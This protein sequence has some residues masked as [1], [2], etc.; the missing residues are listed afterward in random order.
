MCIHELLHARPERRVQ[1]DTE[2]HGSVV[3]RALTTLGSCMEKLVDAHCARPPHTAHTACA[4]PSAAS[5]ATPSPPSLPPVVQ[6]TPPS[7]GFPQTQVIPPSLSP[8]LAPPLSLPLSLPR[9]PL[10]GIVAAVVVKKRHP[11]SHRFYYYYY[12]YDSDGHPCLHRF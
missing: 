8:S 6:G 4:A 11:F 7:R 2:P 5:R 3:E 9:T 12:C 10:V 1:F